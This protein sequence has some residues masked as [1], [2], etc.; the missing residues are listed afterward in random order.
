MTAYEERINKVIDYID[1]HYDSAFSLKEL[2]EVA[3][4]S[5]YHFQRIF[6]AFM[7]ES[8]LKYINRRRIE[9]SMHALFYT[10]K[11][12]TEIA[13]DSGFSSSA[14]YAKTFKKYC[15][16]SPKKCRNLGEA[17]F[18]ELLKMKPASIMED[19]E[20]KVEIEKIDDLTVAYATSW[21]EYN[22]EIP[23]AWFRLFSWAG[24]KRFL[25]P[26][27]IKLGIAYDNPNVCASEK[28]RYEAC[29]SV[30]HGTVGKGGIRVKKLK[31]GLYATVLYDG[32]YSG[33]Q[34]FF[35]SFFIN[36]FQHSPYQLDDRPALQIHVS[37]NNTLNQKSAK[38]KIC[39]PIT[40]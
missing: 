11:S 10:S 6:S 7:G 17:E 35:D 40:G 16:V 4:F 33:L 15:A 28:L 1:A 32:K 34:S 13:L 23:L 25:L 22:L 24:K 8:P 2:S 29:V 20:Y 12:I 36:W 18:C 39:I 19:F 9:K 30:T 37:K 31:G 26:D 14:N 27:T 21:G 5:E 3:C 38:L